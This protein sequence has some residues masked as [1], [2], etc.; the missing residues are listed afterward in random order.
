MK[1]WQKKFNVNKEIESYTVG[2]DPTIDLNLVLWDCVASSAHAAMLKKIGILNNQECIKLKEELGAIIR[3]DEKNKFVIPQELED[4]HTAIETYLVKKLGNIGKKIHTGRSRNDQVLVATRLYTKAQLQNIIEATLKLAA[5]YVTIAKNN[6][7]VP[8]PGFTHMQKAM[9]SSVGLFFGSYAEALGDNIQILRDVYKL[10]DQNP[11][12]SAAGYGTHFD[13]DREL[14]TRTLGFARLQN[15]TLY[16]QN[17]RGKIES[18]VIHAL[19][20]VLNDCAKLANDLLL[21]TMPQFQYFSIPKEFTTGSSIMPQ[22]KNL[23]IFELVRG[24]AALVQGN[25]NAAT[26]IG[27]KAPSGYNREYQLF[28]KLLITSFAITEETLHIMNATI[29]KIHVHEIN[30]KKD[31]TPELYAT[32]YT[33]GL[34]E[35]G[36]PFRDAYKKVAS[37]IHTLRDQDPIKALGKKKHAGATG[38]LGLEK[39]KKELK[40]QEKWLTEESNSFQ[41]KV[42]A[43]IK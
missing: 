20:Q 1:L 38:N 9:P 39:T 18:A 34:V 26:N 40:K 32:D 5:T 29:Q 8:M 35:K 7:N 27:F 21:F 16:C 13:I 10:N 30:C 37:K 11:L 25:F 22:K 24:K 23:D 36:I 43:L 17:S 2:D 3:L 6:K 28:K 4:C 14:T 12:G 41:K 15:N 31:C 19:L 33:N 42:V